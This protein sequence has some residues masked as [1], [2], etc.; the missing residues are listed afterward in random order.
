M[1]CFKIHLRTWLR[2]LFLRVIHLWASLKSKLLQ[3]NSFALNEKKTKKDANC[4]PPKGKKIFYLSF[5]H[6]L[7]LRHIFSSTL[8]HEEVSELEKSSF[9]IKKNNISL[10][11]NISTIVILV[12]KMFRCVSW[13]PTFEGYLFSLGF[14]QK[15]S[16]MSPV[17]GHPTGNP[18]PM[19]A[20]QNNCIGL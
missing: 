9:R 15:L 5:Y 20:F 8:P 12:K 16:R 17:R 4:F 6:V 1:D 19:Y 14:I 18:P 3:D 11:L 7:R 10:I 2:D 13:S